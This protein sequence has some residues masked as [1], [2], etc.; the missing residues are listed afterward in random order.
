MTDLLCGN[1]IPNLAPLY[2]SEL[3]RRGCAFDENFP[4][5]EDW[6][7]LIQVAMQGDLL[8]TAIRGG[9][10]RNLHSSGVHRDMDLAGQY[11]HGIYKKWI[12]QLSFRQTETVLRRLV[13]EIDTT[14]RGG[15]AQLYFGGRDGC[16]TESDSIKIHVDPRS[17]EV[18]FGF[19]GKRELRRM[20]FDPLNDYVK[21][22]IHSIR[23]FCGQSRIDLP[24]ELTS[25]ALQVEDQAYLFDNVDPQIFMELTGEDVSMDK[26]IVD[27]EYLQTGDEVFRAVMEVKEA[28]ISEL[29]GEIRSLRED[30]DNRS[31]RI[32]RLRGR[33]A[34]MEE[35]MNEIRGSLPFRLAR[36]VSRIT[37]L[38]HLS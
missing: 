12:P 29:D 30:L 28:G 37:G 11:R 38:F 25:N 7:F 2:R 19:G 36:A 20:R 26:L 18:S 27:L 31:A 6:D 16:F 15:S 24:L 3:I 9:L 32:R 33:I 14:G 4:F 5:Y 13:G 23:M 8:F 17:R 22:R 10:Y 21:V 1:F 34:G 35:E